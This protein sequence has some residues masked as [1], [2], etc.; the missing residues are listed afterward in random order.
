MMPAP[1]SRP[2]R[3]LGILL[4]LA[5]LAGPLRAQDVLFFRLGEKRVG[6]VVGLDE[7]NFRLEVV[8]S[9]GADVGQAPKATVSI[10]RKNVSQIE[11]AADPSRDRMLDPS[12]PDR[13]RDAGALWASAQ[14]W[15]TVP[16][17]PAAGIGCALG[18][19]LLESAKPEAAAKA[20]GIFQQIE[21]RAWS[22]D[23]RMVAKQGRLRAMVASGKAKEAVKEA[24]ELAEITENPAVLIEAN[25]LLAEADAA[26]LSQLVEDNPRWEEDPLVIPEHARLYH[27]ALDLYLFPAVFYGSDSAASARGLWGAAQVYDFSGER[28]RALECARDI[29][30]MYPAAPTATLAAQYLESLP[31]KLLA[32]DPEKEA[33]APPPEEPKAREK[34]EKP[35]KPEKKSSP[36]KKSTSKKSH[37]KTP[38]K[39]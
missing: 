13:L 10:P 25:F 17:S 22:E 14:P 16:R 24:L 11:F 26:A 18:D 21:A 5:L 2:P 32:A 31:K 28:D 4:A 12:N 15:L 23:D 8:L 20:L 7:N 30:S 35:A 9:S 36:K 6:K 19:A 29:L 37:A 1:T 34:S 27:R 39:N 38:S 33:A 3:A